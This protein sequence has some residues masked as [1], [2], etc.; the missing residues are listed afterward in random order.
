VRYC[1]NLHGIVESYV[2]RLSLVVNHCIAVGTKSMSITRMILKA[3]PGCWYNNFPFSVSLPIC[4]KHY[5]KGNGFE[6]ILYQLKGVFSPE[7]YR[8]TKSR[9]WFGSRSGTLGRNETC[10]HY[11]EI[12]HIHRAKRIMIIKV[13]KRSIPGYCIRVLVFVRNVICCKFQPVLYHC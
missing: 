9:F 6:L 3:S 5:V 11:L 4:S 2:P 7:V 10:Q 12:C 8:I 13:Y 1:F